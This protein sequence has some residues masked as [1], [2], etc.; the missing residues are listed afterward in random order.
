[1]Y[2]AKRWIHIFICHKYLYGCNVENNYKG[3]KFYNET[4]SLVTPT[5]QTDIS[6]HLPLFATADSCQT[7]QHKFFQW[8]SEL[9]LHV[10]VVLPSL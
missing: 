7:K 9:K 5:P 8:P 3:V 2:A 10:T 1:M 6:A 4:F